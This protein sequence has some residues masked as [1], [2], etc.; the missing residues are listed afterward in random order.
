MVT[1]VRPDVHE[2]GED[3][4]CCICDIDLRDGEATPDADLPPTAGGVETF[5][6]Q[7]VDADAADGCDIDFREFSSTPDEDL[8]IASGGVG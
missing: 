6:R 4:D 3:V 7:I 5:Q 2:N 8:P 1:G